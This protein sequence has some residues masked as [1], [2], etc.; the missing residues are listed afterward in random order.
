MLTF[1]YLNQLATVERA[2]MQQQVESSA[3]F[4]F[5]A[6]LTTFFE[7][8]SLL[9]H[10]SDHIRHSFKAD[11]L[12]T[13]DFF[14]RRVSCASPTISVSAAAP[15]GCRIRVLEAIGATEHNEPGL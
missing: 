14:E 3:S 11:I 9:R 7:G 15:I 4:V 5:S 1:R 6:R 8:V 10:L 12:P 2:H 13:D